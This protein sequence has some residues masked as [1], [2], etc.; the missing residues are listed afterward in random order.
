M[1]DKTEG[2]KG[3]TPEKLAKAVVQQS[4]EDASTESAPVALEQQIIPSSASIVK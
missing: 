3:S 2:Q 1:V 4:Q